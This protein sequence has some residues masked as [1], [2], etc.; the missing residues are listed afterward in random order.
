MIITYTHQDGLYINMTNRCSNRCDFCVRSYGDTIYGD[1]WLEREP[2]VEE[3]L[4]A[5]D[6]Y[7]LSKFSELVFCGYGE[8]TE[9]LY[10]MLAVCRAVRQKSDIAIRL[11][12]NGQS[13]LINGADTTH[14]FTSLFDVVSISL[15]AADAASYDAACHSEFGEDAYPA[16]LAF[17]KNVKP[18]VGEVI[19]TVVDTTIP[20]SAI[21]R[22]RE[23][24]AEIG[25][26]LRVREFI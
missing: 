11:N 26:K 22:C 5:I 6:A 24:A 16:I 1:L 7:D 17:A 21:E 8:P 10:D 15:N 19:L 9:R 4:S 12:T 25:V 14:L 23:I 3:I 2:T 18:Y 13:E 20:P